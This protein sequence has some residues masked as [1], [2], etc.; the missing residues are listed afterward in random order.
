M[1]IVF[2]LALHAQERALDS[3]KAVFQ[4]TTVDSLR[5][6]LAN[7]IGQMYYEQGNYPE[8]IN[9]YNQALDLSQR[10]NYGKGIAGS[11][12]NLGMVKEV[13]GNYTEAIN[14]LFS[15]LKG[16][17]AIHDQEHVAA[18][19]I[20]IA[21]IYMDE[22]NYTDALINI[23]K[24]LILCKNSGNKAY[25]GYTYNIRALIYY[26]QERYT[27][28]LAQHFLALEIR[29]NSGDKSSLADTYS[30]IG[31]V[32]YDLGTELRK[33][34]KADS[35]GIYFDLALKNYLSA[36]SIMEELELF[37]SVAN[38]NVNL[39]SL[40]IQLKKYPEAK[41]YLLKG[42]EMCRQTGSKEG[43]KEAYQGLAELNSLT[44]NY[45][46]ALEDY[47][48]FITYRDSLNN[49]ENTKKITQAQMQYEFDKKEAAAKLEQ[50]KKE[51]VTRAESNKQQVVIWSICGILV[52]VIA[53]AVYVYRSFLQ[54]QKINVEITQQKHIIEEKQKE[55]LDSIYYARRIQRAL[56]T[57]EKYIDRNLN[58]LARKD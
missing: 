44:G 5:S 10:S 35:A 28:S 23:N 39:G 7:E 43:M 16:W 46:E 49:E 18:T 1:L 13:Q 52:L 38:I 24:A 3:L 42:L 53:F 40:H 12:N 15:S 48:L 2:Q 50:E 8:A 26:F 20:N 27:E 36:K 6:D 51:A 19:Y 11:Y 21:I 32:Y 17:E 25:M 45:N 58:K 33:K 30:N 9:Y 55:I 4:K 29:K 47:K 34:G 41:T 37:Q 31:V 22:K 14:N 54:K 56:I 57:S